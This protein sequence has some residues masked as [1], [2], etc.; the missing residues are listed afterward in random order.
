L[1]TEHEP[2]Q[3]HGGHKQ[4]INNPMKVIHALLPVTFYKPL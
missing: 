1:I 4:S 3:G 2:D